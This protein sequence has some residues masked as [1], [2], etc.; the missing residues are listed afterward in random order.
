MKARQA[1]LNTHVLRVVT[2]REIARHATDDLSIDQRPL[3]RSMRQ[4]QRR[5]CGREAGGIVIQ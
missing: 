2:T 4:Q 3:A 5:N 1:D